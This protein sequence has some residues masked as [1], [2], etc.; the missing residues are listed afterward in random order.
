V[1]A[2]GQSE[3]RPQL[4]LSAPP[5]AVLAARL[6]GCWHILRGR[7][8]IYGVALNG[9]KWWDQG[10]RDDL[11]WVNCRFLPGVVVNGVPA[12]EC[13]TRFGDIRVKSLPRQS[14][15]DED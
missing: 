5:G 12:L 4:R 14:G 10:W 13:Q 11:V 6:R 9:G 15:E 1:S 7:R 2:D 3:D 8:V